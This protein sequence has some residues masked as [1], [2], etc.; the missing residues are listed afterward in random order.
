MTV[1]LREGKIY[2]QNSAGRMQ[3]AGKLV[4]RIFI[5]ER[6]PVILLSPRKKDIKGFNVH[7]DVIK[8]DLLCD[9]IVIY[10][11]DGQQYSIDREEG[12]KAGFMVSLSRRLFFIP[13][14]CMRHEDTGRDS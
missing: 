4:D 9:R 5:I 12:F 1:E 14:H 13:L 3:E 10:S 7:A 6:A 2:V 8:T 11:Q